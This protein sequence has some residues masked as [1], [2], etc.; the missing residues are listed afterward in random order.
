MTGDTRR[1]EL[2]PVSAPTAHEAAAGCADLADRLTHQPGEL[3]NVAAAQRND[4]LPG[5]HRHAVVADSV[6]AAVAALRDPA[7]RLSRVDQ[8]T[9][10]GCAFLLAGVGEQYPGMVS[11]LYAEEPRYREH[12]DHCQRILGER[13]DIDVIPVLTERPVADATPPAGDLAGWLG[14][15]TPAH[16][17]TTMHR[18]E[19]AQPAVFVAEYALARLLMDWGIAPRTMLGYSLGEYVAACIAGVMSLPDALHLVAKRAELIAELPGGAMLAVG[20]P[21]AQLRAKVPELGDAGIDIAALTGDQLVLA[22][23]VDAIDSLVVRLLSAQVPCRQ[24]Q[25]THAFHSR[26]LQPAVAPLT[27]WIA[28]NI[29]MNAPRIPYISNVTGREATVD[30]VTDPGYWAR[31]MRR[32]VRFGD[33]AGSV[34]AKGELAFVEL[35]AGQSLGTMLRRHQ[36]CG[37]ERWPLIVG[38]LPT[39]DQ[40]ASATAHVTEALA[41][42]WL[43]GVPI[44]WHA[45]GGTPANEQPG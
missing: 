14:R 23:P 7:K 11:D 43:A 18:T 34:L 21:P 41:R 35:G 9:G 13:W 45:Y 39:A 27:D 16:A 17:T 22:G 12:V 31:H 44:D 5:P 20:L 40:S 25:T 28:R 37:T 42:L 2:L 3:A 29:S 19:I 36:D 26:M 6:A 10:R 1:W 15:G 24:L 8:T 30:L 38:T 32:P 4:P 33:G